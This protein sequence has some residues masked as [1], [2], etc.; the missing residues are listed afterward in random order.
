MD[1]P[2]PL[3]GSE[4]HLLGQPVIRLD[5]QRAVHK[6]FRKLDGI[7]TKPLAAAETPGSETLRQGGYID[8]NLQ[9]VLV[10]WGERDA[11]AQFLE[12][13]VP[14]A[15]RSQDF[16]DWAAQIRK[17]INPDLRPTKSGCGKQPC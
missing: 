9:R 1:G 5:R 17:G 15:G 16:Q 7:E 13:M 4:L 10:D 11:V 12:R 8:M 6:Q 14:K 3:A 2:L